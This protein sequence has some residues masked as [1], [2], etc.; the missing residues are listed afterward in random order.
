[1]ELP[2]RKDRPRT[3]ISIK[4]LD[5][6]VIEVSGLNLTVG[7]HTFTRE[8]DEKEL[9]ESWIFSNSGEPPNTSRKPCVTEK[10]I[11]VL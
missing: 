2:S 11:D 8:S 7:S 6:A 5:G 1:M 4:L 10:T 9:K 3:S